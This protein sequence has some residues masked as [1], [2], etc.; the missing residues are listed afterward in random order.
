MS[1]IL[2]A[3]AMA[4]TYAEPADQAIVQRCLDAAEDAAR[5]FLQRQFYVDASAL[6]AALATVP[7]LRADARAAYAAAI[8]AADT[9]T[10]QEVQ[11]EAKAD[12]EAALARSLTAAQAIQDGIVIKP[13]IV[14]A[15]LL[16]CA[17]LYANREDVIVGTIAAVLPNGAESLLWPSRIGLGI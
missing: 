2:I 16:T 13:A 6:A 3:D 14:A 10:D 7:T 5:D 1:V 9:I 4:H 15:C 17:H 8:A 11:A 12:A